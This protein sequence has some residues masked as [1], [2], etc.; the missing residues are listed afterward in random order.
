MQE[1]GG[2]AGGAE[3]LAVLLTS[4]QNGI[5]AKVGNRGL[6]E[7]GRVKPAHGGR[8]TVLEAGATA[9]AALAQVDVQCRP[10]LDLVMG[11]CAHVA[12]G[13]AR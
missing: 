3:L 2:R 5:G 4:G 13:R 1:G 7:G 8:A 12:T 10:R 6:P 11:D 9:T